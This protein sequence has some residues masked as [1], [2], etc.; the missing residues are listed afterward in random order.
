MFCSS[1]TRNGSNMWHPQVL[2]L[3]RLFRFY[4]SS[5]HRKTFK[6]TTSVLQLFHQITQWI[7]CLQLFFFFLNPHAQDL[8]LSIASLGLSDLL[9]LI[10]PPVTEPAK[11][12]EWTYA[13][14]LTFHH[15]TSWQ[16]HNGFHCRKKNWNV[17]ALLI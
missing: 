13:Q 5:L 11:I 8:C 3:K 10:P 2:W 16:S 12:P 14:Q 15:V 9:P 4:D 7:D 1:V 6:T 17:H